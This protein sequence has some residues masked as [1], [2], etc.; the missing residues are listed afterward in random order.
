VKIEEDVFIEA[1]QTQVTDEALVA[2]ALA[3]G[4]E[5]FSPIVRRYKDAIFGVSLARLRH[6][7]DAEDIAQQAFIE[8][9][10]RLHKL[11]EP[12]R[13]GAWLRSIAIHRSINHIQRQRHAVELNEVE[14]VDE[15]TPSPQEALERSELRA[16]VLSAIGRLSKVQRETVALY[17]ISGYSQQEVAAMQEVPLGT[18]KHRLHAAR[19]KLKEEMIDMVEE[20]LKEGAPDENFAEKVFDLLSAFPAGGKVWNGDIMEKLKEAGPAGEAGF[21]KA[22]ATPHWKTRRAATHYIGVGDTLPLDKSVMLLNKAL[23]DS[24]LK[25][26]QWAVWSLMWALDVDEAYRRDEFVPLVLP[27][28]FDP[29]KK[30]RH[31]VAGLLSQPSCAGAVPLQTVARA[32]AQERDIETLRRMQRLVQNVLDAQEGKKK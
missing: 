13:L 1:L 14:L 7:D 21:V 6:F 20:V 31:Q 18:V 11:K 9:F 29:S 15:E 17:Y 32:L 25:V 28:L 2:Q 10:E 22:L 16:Q 3:G 5:D 8:A 19:H 23:A 26:R 12:Q 27:L 24:N 4:P 30:I